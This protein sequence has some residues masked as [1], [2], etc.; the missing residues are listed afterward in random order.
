MRNIKKALR[1]LQYG[2]VIAHAT[3]TCYGLACDMTNPTAVAKLFGIKHRPNDMPVSALF[4][5]I[6]EAKK[7]VEWNALAEDLA[8]TYLPG[9]LTLILPLKK[10]TIIFSCLKSNA[11]SLGIRIS[12]HPIARRLAK[13]FGKPLSTTSANLHGQ[14]NPY[15]V[16]DIVPC[17]LILDSGNLPEVPPSKVVDCTGQEPKMLRL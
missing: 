1:I 10:N 2:G 5:S 4:T 14:P 13:E 6:E 11:S 9:P 15:C 7:Y 17:D 3:E 12:S 16:D 8:T